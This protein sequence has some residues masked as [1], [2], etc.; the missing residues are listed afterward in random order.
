LQWRLWAQA[1]SRKG[2]VNIDFAASVQNM[3][4][5]SD[6][7][8]C[9]TDLL[10]FT[11]GRRIGLIRIAIKAAAGTNSRNS[12]NRFALSGQLKGLMPVT[13][14][15][16]R[17]RLATRPTLSGSLP[18]QTI[19]IVEVAALAASPVTVPPAARITAT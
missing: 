3:D 12:P 15:A 2:R 13:F 18:I 11:L 19:G 10:R 16:G 17:L 7:A 14:P 8:R 9:C 4:L 5:L 1:R 6:G